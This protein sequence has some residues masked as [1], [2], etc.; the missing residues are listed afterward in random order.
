MDPNRALL[1]E[2]PLMVLKAD[3]KP[4]KGTPAT[5]ESGVK[6]SNYQCFLFTDL[7][8]IA[9]RST[10]TSKVTQIKNTAELLKHSFTYKYHFPLYNMKLQNVDDT[11]GT[12]SL[13][14]Y[15]MI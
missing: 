15:D 2:A 14:L 5:K 12:Y 1:R 6:I 4:V 8:L 10:I 3:D 7:L 13:H 11:E 9:A